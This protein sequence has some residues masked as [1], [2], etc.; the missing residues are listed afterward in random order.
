MEPTTQ[1]ASRWCSGALMCSLLLLVACS[2][3]GSPGSTEPVAQD[4]CSVGCGSLQSNCLLES[5]RDRDAKIAA[6][7]GT[8]AEIERCRADA[9]RVREAAQTVCASAQSSCATCCGAGG[10]SCAA[11]AP[12]VP[13]FAGSFTLPARNTLR[14]LELPTGAAGRGKLLLDL[15]EAQLIVDPDKRTPV[16]AAAECAT[17]VLAC[18]EKDR[19]NW[20]G[21]FASV[22]TCPTNTPWTSD[23]PMCC[24]AACASR[25]Q[26]LRRAGHPGYRAMSAA[27]WAAPSCM[28]GLQGAPMRTSP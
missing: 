7:S 3:A 23:G 27:I 24:P 18:S 2:D 26:D 9:D 22:P 25:Y 16:T 21:C 4:Q 11:I 20:A 13:K 19:R 1:W 28:P 12:E 6:C 14:T 5:T 10:S 15:P 17:A 8:S